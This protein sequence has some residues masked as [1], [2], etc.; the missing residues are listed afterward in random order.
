MELGLQGK[1]AIV[2]GA[3]GGIGRQIA[4][5]FS[6]YGMKVVICDI[7]ELTAHETMQMIS[8][9][10]L[11]S[12]KDLAKVDQ[13]RSLVEETVNKYG[14]LDVLVNTAG[15]L[16]RIAIE[17]VDEATWDLVFDVNLKSLFFLSREA[18]V[19]MKSH[20]GG[21]VINFSSQ[22]GFTGG[23]S[24]SAVYNATKGAILTLTKSF[25]RTYATDGICV[26]AIAPG[27][28][29]TEMMKLPQA[30]L[31]KIINLVPMQRLG[32]PDEMAG[33]VLFLASDW[34]SYITGATIDVT[35]GQLMR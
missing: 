5:A 33:T 10:H 23:F 8:G 4:K 15:I 24:Q 34:S 26:N 25:A 16:R 30:E 13:C 32:R 21:R 6:A 29:D 35:G 9:D 28:V 14:R 18:C 17:E 7:N 20:G 1:V 27:M 22:G 12:V 2:T 19:Y 11:V 3:G 31:D